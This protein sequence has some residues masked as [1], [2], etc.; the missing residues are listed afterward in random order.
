MS[1]LDGV[2]GSSAARWGTQIHLLCSLCLLHYVR[3]VAKSFVDQNQRA[4][5]LFVLKKQ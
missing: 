4:F 2:M 3:V 5:Y 1:T